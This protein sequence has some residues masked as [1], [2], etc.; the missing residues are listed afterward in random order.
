MMD[1]S[2]TDLSNLRIR[3]DRSAMEGRDTSTILALLDAY[4]DAEEL[5]PIAEELEMVKATNDEL[6]SELRDLKQAARVLVNR[7]EAL[8]TAHRYHHKNQLCPLCTE[9]ENAA[10]S[11]KEL[12]R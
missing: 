12:S 1:L 8:A 10:K 7:A 11:T 3:A 2:P 9:V 4:E 5:R 6:E